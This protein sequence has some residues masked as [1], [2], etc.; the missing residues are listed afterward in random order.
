MVY[1]YDTGQISIFSGNLIVQF[2]LYD[3]LR[4]S[5]TVIQRVVVRFI[6]HIIQY[7]TNISFQLR[8]IKDNKKFSILMP[9][10]RICI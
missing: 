9:S 6:G 10:A 4:I 2:P 5:K 8:I 7:D 3:V 1:E